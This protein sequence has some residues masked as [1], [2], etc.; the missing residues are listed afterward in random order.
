MLDFDI[1][2]HQKKTKK[3]MPA[4]DIG[5]HKKKKTWMHALRR[6]SHTLIFVSKDPEAKK[7]PYGWKSTTWQS[8]FRV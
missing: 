5:V 3:N 2:V 8:L 4:F 1:S 6:I 7:A